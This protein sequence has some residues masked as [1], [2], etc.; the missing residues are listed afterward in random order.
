MAQSF[1]SSVDTG[2]FAPPVPLTNR[3]Y[4]F[5]SYRARFHTVEGSPVKFQRL[6]SVAAISVAVE[7]ARER[8]VRELR[9]MGFL[10]KGA[11][12][13]AAIRKRGC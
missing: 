1:V 3:R 4:R 7:G 13:A 11:I 12:D 9:I 8:E 6:R 10:S 5:L 2:S